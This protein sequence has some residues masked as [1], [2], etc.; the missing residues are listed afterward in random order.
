MLLLMSNYELL[1]RSIEVEHPPR[2]EDLWTQHADNQGSSARRYG[3]THPADI[4]DFRSRSDSAQ[5]RGRT[6]K[7][8]KRQQT[9]SHPKGEQG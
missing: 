8:A 1:F 9:S 7:N 3:H 6:S 4:P 5:S 2:Y